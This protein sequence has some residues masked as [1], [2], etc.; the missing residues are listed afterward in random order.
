MLLFELLKLRWVFL[1]ERSIRIQKK[2][3]TVGNGA[4]PPEMFS[5][6]VKEKKEEERRQKATDSNQRVK[7]SKRQVVWN[8]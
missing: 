7:R 8:Q 1:I 4:K 2:D 5:N 6:N 3:V